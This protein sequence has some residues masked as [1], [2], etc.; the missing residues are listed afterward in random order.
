MNLINIIELAGISIAVILLLLLVFKRQ[1]IGANTES[2][3]RR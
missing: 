1:P 3:V 2:T